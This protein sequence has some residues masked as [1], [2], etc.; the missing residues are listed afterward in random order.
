MKYGV[1]TNTL[2]ITAGT[3]W[4]LAGVN[5][6][7]IGLTCWIDDGHYWLF[8]VCG[9]DNGDGTYTITPDLTDADGLSQFVDDILTTY[10]VTKNSEGKLNGFE[11]MKFRVTAADYTA[12][13]FTV[14]PR[15]TF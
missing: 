5:I 15:P 8:K 3:I 7:R 12:K 13:K 11:E 9:V 4:S 6:L 14:I 2:L 10:F 1:S